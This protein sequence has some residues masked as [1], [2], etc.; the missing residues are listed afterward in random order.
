MLLS[1]IIICKCL[2]SL[3]CRGTLALSLRKERRVMDQGKAWGGAGR[4]GVNG[5]DL[6]PDWSLTETNRKDYLPVRL[7]EA[8]EG[9][10]DQVTA[11]HRK[12]GGS[13]AG[14][15]WCCCGGGDAAVGV[16]QEPTWNPLWEISGESRRRPKGK[17]W[18]PA[19]VSVCLCACVWMNARRVGWKFI[20]VLVIW[21]KL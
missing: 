21:A 13:Q 12:W 7:C 4:G 6:H 17:N 20:S 18:I 16:F 1:P 10:K 14:K 3:M 15:T 19:S 5:M 8:W 11:V 2:C 9:D